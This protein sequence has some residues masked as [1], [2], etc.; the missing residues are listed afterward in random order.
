MYTALALHT[1]TE[2]VWSVILQGLQYAI[3]VQGR[4]WYRHCNVLQ[5]VWSSHWVD[6]ANIEVG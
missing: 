5:A 2:H 3:Q 1:Y 6:E 4:D